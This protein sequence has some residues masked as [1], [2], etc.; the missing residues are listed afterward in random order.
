MLKRLASKA[1]AC[2]IP[3]RKPARLSGPFA[4]G[5][6]SFAIGADV[7]DPG[8]RRPGIDVYYP[9]DRRQA[10]ALAAT[11]AA[12]A[13]ATTPMHDRWLLPDAAISRARMFP[14]V[15]YLP[16]WGGVRYD[17]TYL[18]A[19]LASHGH[20]V[21]ALDDIDQVF[22]DDGEIHG[23]LDF[24]SAGA[25]VTTM[26]LWDRRQQRSVAF[27]GGV[28]SRLLTAENNAQA[29]IFDH[30]DGRKIGVLGFSFGAS[31]ACDLSRVDHRVGCVVNLDGWMLGHSRTEGPGK[32]ALIINGDIGWIAK[33][34]AS[35]D[36]GYRMMAETSSADLALQRRLAE[37]GRAEAFV[38]ERA[39]HLDFTDGLFSPTL[40]TWL[41]QVSWPLR[42]R[43]QIHR[44]LLAYLRVFLDQHLGAGPSGKDRL[45]FCDEARWFRPLDAPATRMSAVHW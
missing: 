10:D 17:N 2:R 29:R 42:N 19:A 37:K 12:G 20:V 45:P 32:P 8:D 23:P 22:P 1:L 15:V 34:L 40:H 36:D 43:L 24:S 4:V 21:V 25:F 38:V 26:A 31:V 30:V 44:D 13:P 16:G 28:L 6:S 14:L 35:R 3:S 18:L 41:K 11:R 39:A 9:V 27:V 33:A 7:A 5:F